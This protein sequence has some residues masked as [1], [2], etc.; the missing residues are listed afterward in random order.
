MGN[1]LRSMSNPDESHSWLVNF[2]VEYFSSFQNPLYEHMIIFGQTM[3][4]AR[5]EPTDQHVLRCQIY[6]DNKGPS[7]FLPFLPKRRWVIRCFY[8]DPSW[9]N[10]FSIPLAQWPSHAPWSIW[11]A[12]GHSLPWMWCRSTF[13]PWK[14]STNRDFF[15]GDLRRSQGWADLQLI[16]PRIHRRVCSGMNQ[17]R[18]IWRPRIWDI[19]EPPEG[20][21][22]EGSA[23]TNSGEQR[24]Q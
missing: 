1:G 19:R 12:V 3:Q 8:R 22:S 4:K 17:P 15:A 24:W 2:Q 9:Q 18:A 13:H 14:S 21:R 6:C 16:G 23:K 5:H 11:M 10:M 20:Q 7:A